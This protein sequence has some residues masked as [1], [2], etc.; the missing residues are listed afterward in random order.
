MVRKDHEKDFLEFSRS[1]RFCSPRTVD[2]YQTDLRVLDCYSRSRGIKEPSFEGISGFITYLRE[3]RQNSPVTV[4]RKLATLNNYLCYLKIRGIIDK[5][6]DLLLELPR[7][8]HPKRKLPKHLKEEENEGRGT[9]QTY[10]R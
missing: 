2:A 10:F 9:M 6:E 5:G 4:A 1:V 3:E 8:R 7:V